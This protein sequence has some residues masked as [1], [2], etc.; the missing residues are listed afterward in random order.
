MNAVNNLSGPL[1]AAVV[2][3][4]AAAAA[5]PFALPPLPYAFDALEPYVD[6]ATMEIHHGRHH[7]AYVD[8]LN[9]AVRSQGLEGRDLLSL[10]REVSKHGPAVRN[11][12]G[13]HYNHDLFWRLMAPAG[14]GG[15]PSQ[16]LLAAMDRDLG[17]LESF[18]K[19][20]TEAGLKRFGSGWAWLVVTP[21]KRLVVTS[22]PNQDNP[23]MDVAE[24]KG[25]PILGLDVWEHA[26]YLKYQNR[27][28]DYIQGWWQV[29]NWNEVNRLFDLATRQS[30]T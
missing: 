15:V 19:Q 21:E 11:N 17:G 29:V 6:K 25:T 13:G 12:G 10:L 27:R 7:K 9:A 5:D 22:T 20:F 30:R 14:K 8:N 24:V 3:I 4:P 28:G 26:Y 2:A 18:Q 1:A 16:A 23:L